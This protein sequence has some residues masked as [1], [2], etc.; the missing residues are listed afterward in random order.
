MRFKF[1]RKKSEKI[2]RNSKRGI[3]FEEVQEIWEHPYYE[4][5]RS[6]EPEQFRAIGWVKGTLYSVIFENRQDRDGEYIHIITLWKST[7][8]E[9]GLYEESI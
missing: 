9:R 8:Q 5:C 3:D 7:Q 1:D 4:D 6:D 2:K